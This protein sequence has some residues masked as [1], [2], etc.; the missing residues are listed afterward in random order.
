MKD[1]AFLMTLVNFLPLPPLQHKARVLIILRDVNIKSY[2]LNQS[3]FHMAAKL[4]DLLLQG[5]CLSLNLI[6]AIKCWEI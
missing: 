5:L 2:K 1:S 4:Q 3:Y 6:K